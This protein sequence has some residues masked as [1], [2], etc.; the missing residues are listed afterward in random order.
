MTNIFG[1]TIVIVDTDALIGLFLKTDALHQRCLKIVKFL[2]AG[3]FLVYISYPTIL[4]AATALAKDKAIKRPDLAAKLL[5]D[6][7]SY[8]NPP[9]N[10]AV[11]N[12][13]AQ[14]YHPKT[15]KKNSPFDY[16]LL[17]LAKTNNIKFVFSFD[18]FYQKHGLTL[19]ESLLS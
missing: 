11:I 3:N 19:I 7:A 15:S 9:I 5:Q 10:E 16:Y 12:L 8:E 18:S 14:L 6:Y 4:E 2:K 17:A 1:K 13:V